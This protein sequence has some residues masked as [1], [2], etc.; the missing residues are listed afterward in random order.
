MADAGWDK[1]DEKRPFGKTTKFS[2]VAVI[3]GDNIP[4][5]QQRHEAIKAM[6]AGRATPEQ[7]SLVHRTDE[8]IQEALALRD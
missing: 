3:G 2:T 5:S 7:V 4:H 8:I 1:F 6:K